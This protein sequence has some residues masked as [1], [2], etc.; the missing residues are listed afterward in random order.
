DGPNDRGLSRRQIVRQGDASLRRLGVEHLDMDLIHDTAPHTPL[1]ETLRAPDDL[2]RQG[3]VR[4][5]GAS[6]MPAWLMTK[7]LWISDKYLLHRF[8]WV[9]N[10]YSLLARRGA[11]GVCS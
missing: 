1:D 9:Q 4:Y 8:E 11:R 5:L 7:A 6:N 3:K 2:V 10:W